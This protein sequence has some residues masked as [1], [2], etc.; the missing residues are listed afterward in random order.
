MNSTD[1]DT[2]IRNTVDLLMKCPKNLE[3]RLTRK[4]QSLWKKRDVQPNYAL[5][6]RHS[7]EDAPTVD[8]GAQNDTRQGNSSN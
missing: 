4:L 2:K 7:V 5:T 1:V 3:P 6:T 8:A